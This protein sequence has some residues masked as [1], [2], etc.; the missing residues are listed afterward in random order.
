MATTD[1]TTVSIVSHWSGESLLSAWTA[2][3]R[4]LLAD[5]QRLNDLNVFPVPDGDTGTNMAATLHAGLVEANQLLVHQNTRADTAGAAIARGALMKANGNSGLILS[6][7]LLGFSQ[8]FAGK[9][10]IDGRDFATGLQNASDLAYRAVIEPVE[11]TILTVLRV[12][13]LSAI[14]TAKESMS[15]NKVLASAL[16]EAEAALAKT[17]AQL[18]TLRRAGVVDAGGLGFVDLLRAL[19][20]FERG[21][22]GDLADSRFKRLSNRNHSAHGLSEYG[23]CTNFMVLGSALPVEKLRSELA[24]Y[25]SSAV[26]AGDDTMIKVHIH[27]ENPGKLLESAMSYGELIEISIEN[28]NQQ[29]RARNESPRS[30]TVAVVA[31]VEGTGLQAIFRSLGATVLSPPVRGPDSLAVWLSSTLEESTSGQI[32]LIPVSEEIRAAAFEVGPCSSKEIQVVESA[33]IP[34]GLAALAVHKEAL[35]PK[36]NVKAMNEAIGSVHTVEIRVCEAA[37]PESRFVAFVDGDASFATGDELDALITGLELAGAS[38]SELI[39]IFVGSRVGSNSLDFE[40]VSVM[41]PNAEL[42]ILDGG[43]SEPRYAIAIE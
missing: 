26:I 41:F 34:Q 6:Q 30:A 19:L 18:H 10:V 17:T 25:G 40:R 8:A 9:H 35:D 7:I 36:S 11:G 21:D 29:V 20:S 13:S 32:V 1:S 15:L 22:L 38:S 28:M 27:T 23:Y 39:T 42:D 3:H 16:T 2:A 43:Q 4:A 14:T 24:L 12:A 37:E 5:E 33:T 31:I